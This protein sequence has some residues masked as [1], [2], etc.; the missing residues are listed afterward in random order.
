MSNAAAKPR[1]LVN[2]R[3]TDRVSAL[4]RGFTLGDGLFET[5]AVRAGRALLWREHMQRLARGCERLGLPRP[6]PRQLEREADR[7]R[8]GE[9]DGTLR[10]TLTRGPGERGYAVP[11]APAPT[12]AVAWFPGIPAFPREVLRLRWCETRL[13]ENPVL[14][15]LKHLNRLEQILARSE[16]CDERID[17]GIMR[18]VGGDVIEC[19]SCNLFL[20]SEGVLRTPE[21]SSCGVA[22]VVRG[23]VLEIAESLAIPVIVDRV[24]PV[25]V[26]GARELFV[27][28]AS[29]GVAPVGQLDD[30]EWDAPGAVTARISDTFLESLR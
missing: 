20:V 11:R 22:G 28:N 7:C 10:L 9:A 25:D 5:I 26:A 27:T 29:R 23:R 3:S 6:D 8:S 19:T 13:A 15:G 14:A 21:L 1:T 24:T 30:R 17:E 2:G 12:R 18:S 4:D 16:W